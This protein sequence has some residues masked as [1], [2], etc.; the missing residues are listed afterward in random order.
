ME[1][2]PTCRSRRPTF[3]AL[4]LVAVSFFALSYVLLAAC[5]G[6]SERA[7]PAET[8]TPAEPELTPP[9]DPDAIPFEKPAPYTRSFALLRIRIHPAQVAAER[10][11]DGSVPKTID[12]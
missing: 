6:G 12:K 5:S 1:I 3:P 9:D 10:R 4:R 2:R 11:G 7:A 8:I